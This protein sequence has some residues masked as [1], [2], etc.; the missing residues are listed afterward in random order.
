MNTAKMAKSLHSEDTSVYAL[1]IEEGGWFAVEI[2]VTLRA[3]TAKNVYYVGSRELD[4][5]FDGIEA[6]P[7]TSGSDYY[8]LTIPQ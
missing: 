5:I 1:Y 8:V 2:S 3:N 4:Y 6:K 7:D